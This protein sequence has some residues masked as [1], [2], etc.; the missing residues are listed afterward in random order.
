MGM[1][2]CSLCL[3][4]TAWFYYEFL[5]TFDAPWAWNVAAL[6]CALVAAPFAALI[7]ILSTVEY[8]TVHQAS[9]YCFFLL[10]VIAVLCYTRMWALIDAEAFR[11]KL[12]ICAVLLVNFTIYLPVGMAVVC[13]WPRLSLLDL[14]GCGGVSDGGAV[15]ARSAARTGLE[16]I[17]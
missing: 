4:P 2:T 11:V 8:P 10:Q 1:T 16:V 3:I 9:A 12:A 7:A 5:R 14:A 6:A 17:R 13:D 15:A